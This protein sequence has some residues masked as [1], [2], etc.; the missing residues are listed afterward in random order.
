MEHIEQVRDDP[1]RSSQAIFTGHTRAFQV[2]LTADEA[3]RMKTVLGAR[4]GIQVVSAL[5][6]MDAAILAI[7]EVM[8]RQ[9][10]L[11]ESKECSYYQHYLVYYDSEKNGSQLTH[12]AFHV[13]EKNCASAQKRVL[14]WY[15]A[16]EGNTK[17]IPPILERQADFWE[18]KV[19]A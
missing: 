15:D 16:N 1:E 8:D 17:E 5:Q 9:E 18:K 3:T 19:C 2:V 12:E 13:A 7:R 10:S 4:Y 14:D 6:M 11:C